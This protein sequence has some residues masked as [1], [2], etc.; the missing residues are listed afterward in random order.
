MAR[1]LIIDEHFGSGVFDLS[2]F[3]Q[4]FNLLASTRDQ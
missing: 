2:G 4:I 1:V 3:P